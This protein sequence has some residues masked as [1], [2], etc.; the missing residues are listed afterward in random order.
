MR[1]RFLAAVKACG[2]GAVLSHMSA[3]ALW[4]LVPWDD[5]RDPDVIARGK[6]RVAGVNAHRSNKPPPSIRY[7]GIP[8]TT[9]VRTLADLS[10]V[11]P[12]KALRRA[13]REALTRKRITPH[14]AGTILPEATPSPPAATSRTSSST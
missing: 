3:A 13:V 4:E 2:E 7:D 6:R 10:S 11:L 5:Q 12:F 14:E 9:P 1:G 8:I